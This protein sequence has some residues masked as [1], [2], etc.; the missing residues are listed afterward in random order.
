MK[1]RTE[2]SKHETKGVEVEVERN[3]KKKNVSNIY[4]WQILSLLV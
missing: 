2:N 3:P 1:I 4:T